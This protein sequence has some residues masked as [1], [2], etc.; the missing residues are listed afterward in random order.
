[1]FGKNTF[2]PGIN[3]EKKIFFEI[4]ADFVQ[5]AGISAFFHLLLQP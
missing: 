2:F 3:A 1:M 5:K 4:K